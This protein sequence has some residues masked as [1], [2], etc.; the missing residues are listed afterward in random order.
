MQDICSDET[1]YGG[2]LPVSTKNPVNKA[3]SI[4]QKLLNHAKAN[5][6]D[7]QRTLDAYAIECILARLAHSV[8]A[9]KFL[10]KGALLFAVWKGLRT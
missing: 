1:V 9:D 6:Q 2:N 10:L 7:F 3:A 5:G 8:Y 4:R